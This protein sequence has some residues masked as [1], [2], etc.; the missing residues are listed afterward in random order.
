MSVESTLVRRRIRRRLR[1][2]GPRVATL[3]TLTAFALLAQGCRA[4][5]VLGQIRERG[6][7]RVVTLNLPTCYYI[8]ARG[9][10]GL[11]Y[12]L[13]SR[14]A[15]SLGLRLKIYAVPNEADM[16]SDLASGRADIAAA[17]ITSNTPWD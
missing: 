7:L 14:F 11:E 9:P 10:K 8:G 15:A 5:S 6:E 2:V 17:Q 12:D 3:T 4:P 13:A 16:R 1:K